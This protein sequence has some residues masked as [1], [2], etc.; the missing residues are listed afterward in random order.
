M[1]FISLVLVLSRRSCSPS[2]QPHS[3]PPKATILHTLPIISR[4]PPAPGIKF[5][6]PLAH[7]RDV[8]PTRWRHRRDLAL[9]YFHK[10]EAG[11]P[12]LEVIC[13]SG[14]TVRY[15][16]S[17]WKLLLLLSEIEDT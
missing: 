3:L 2:P 5:L 1:R 12:F 8:A 15:Q 14:D 7:S 11:F 6:N 13:N 10:R 17:T 4:S 9:Q 16:E